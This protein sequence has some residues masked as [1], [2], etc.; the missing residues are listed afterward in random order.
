MVEG[1]ENGVS[2]L[3]CPG[4]ISKGR[5]CPGSLRVSET[6]KFLNLKDPGFYQ[7]LDPRLGAYGAARC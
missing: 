6:S 2:A 4:E 1:L 5:D 7:K 3:E